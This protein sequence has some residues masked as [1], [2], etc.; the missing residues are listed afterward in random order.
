MFCGAELDRIIRYFSTPS[1]HHEWI[2]C[3]ACSFMVHIWIDTVLFML[4][5][6]LVGLVKGKK[7]IKMHGVSNFKI[8][9]L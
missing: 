2:Q 4:Y 9:G 6:H 7:L 3:T 8:V 5:L 1:V